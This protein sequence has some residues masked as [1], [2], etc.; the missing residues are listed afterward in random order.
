MNLEDLNV[1][2]FKIKSEYR[3]GGIDLIMEGEVDMENPSLALRPYLETV[4][5]TVI[6]DSIKRVK[7]NFKSVSF[8]NSSGIKEFVHWVLKLNS[9]PDEQK[10]SIIILY[11]LNVTWQATSLPVIQKLQPQ[12]IQ[13][14]ND[15]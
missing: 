1:E 14:E 10:Y 2:K 6:R 4:H 5:E 15:G 8:M 7:V 3:D 12:Y 13:L 9:I 11:S